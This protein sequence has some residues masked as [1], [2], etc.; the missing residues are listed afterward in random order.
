[1]MAVDSRERNFFVKPCIE[2]GSTTMSSHGNTEQVQQD[3]MKWFFGALLVSVA[4]SAWLW[5]MDEKLSNSTGEKVLGRTLLELRG[6]QTSLPSGVTD[7]RQTLSPFYV[8]PST[9]A[10]HEEVAHGEGH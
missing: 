1:M 6:A 10:H 2:L 3:G 8:Q 5:Q 7:P 4:F 9:E